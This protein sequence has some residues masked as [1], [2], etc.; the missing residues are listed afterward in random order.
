[1]S[2]FLSQAPKPQ[3][4]TF[5]GELTAWY[6]MRLSGFILLAMALFHLFYMLFL[7]PG[8]ITGISYQTIIARWT[9]PTLGFTWR[10]FD[11]HLLLLSLTHGVNGIRQ[12]LN[13]AP[14]Q[15]V[16]QRVGKALLLIIYLGLVGVGT[17]IIL[18]V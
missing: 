7:I 13:Q 16:W 3:R 5:S 17:G 14:V 6:F 12:M 4:P 18:T 9:H 1:M 11:L 10:L 8:G 15:P 2:Q